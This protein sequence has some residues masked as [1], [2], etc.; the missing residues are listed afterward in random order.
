MKHK[1]LKIYEAGKMSGLTYDEMNNWRREL[2][3]KLEDEAWNKSY[4]IDVINPVYFYNFESVK[5]QNDTEV[6]DYDLAHVLSS[7]I[8]VVNLEGLDT[9]DGSKIEIH[10][11]YYNNKIPVVAFGDKK[12]FEE[13]HPWIKTSITRVEKDMDEVVN[14]IKDF[15]MV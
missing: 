2:K 15:Y 12:L 7:D 6:K 14:Y 5:Y 3:Y 11:A 4:V 10:D 1:Y 13:L 8:I 9:S